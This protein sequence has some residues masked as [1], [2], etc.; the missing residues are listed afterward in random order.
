MHTKTTFNGSILLSWQN[1]ITNYLPDFFTLI[2][3]PN[4]MGKFIKLS[5]FFSLLNVSTCLNVFAHSVSDV[6]QSFY[7][8][9]SLKSLYMSFGLWFKSIKSNEF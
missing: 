3:L 5:E 2:E 1:G 7:V 6:S 8:F 4:H 9:P